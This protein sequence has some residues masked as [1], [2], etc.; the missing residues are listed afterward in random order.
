VINIYST[1]KRYEI[2]YADPA[3]TYRDKASAGERGAFHKYD[4]MTDEEIAAL[5]VGRIASDSC[6]LFMWATW[7]KV[8]EA[9]WV[10]REWGFIYR[11]VA[12]VWVKRNDP[13]GSLL[14]GMGQWTRS[15]TEFCL[16][17][18]RGRP[19]RVSASVHQ[20]VEAS[21]GR[22]SAKPPVVRD[23]IV[24]LMGDLSRIELF[25]RERARG[26]DSWGNELGVA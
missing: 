1:R 13:S 18:A 4:L 7:P 24:A 22:H 9:L 16:L 15:N 10:M 8:Q 19:S 26:W 11:T 6:A 12:F 2:V 14:W 20:V 21:A 17:G 3:W 5:P 23:R 25:A